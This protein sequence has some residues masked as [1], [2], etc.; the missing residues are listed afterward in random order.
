MTLDAMHMS[1]LGNDYLYF[2][3]LSEEIGLD[4][5]RPHVVK[6]SAQA[7]TDGVIV[8]LAHEQAHVQMVIFNRDGSRA[9]MCGNGLR[10]VVRYVLDYL[11]D[12]QEIL[13]ETDAGPMLGI[14]T[15]DGEICVRLDPPPRIVWPT[16]TLH[17]DQ[18]A[19]V[20][21]RV[22]VGNPHVVI[23]APLPLK[24]LPLQQWGPAIEQNQSLFPE[25]TNVEF[26]TIDKPGHLTMR[27]W[28]RGSGETKACG[29]GAAAVA[30]TYRQQHPQL[31]C[32]MVAMPGGILCFDWNQGQFFMTGPATYVRTVQINPTTFELMSEVSA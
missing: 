23:E 13:V 15:G 22:S 25:K 6:L 30:W 11:T 8:M 19:L 14:E 3:G 7:Q 17:L 21:H 32:V 24:D 10:C 9:Q 26:Y 2:D 27:V 31:D 4:Q 20:Y 28:E 29:T 5:L 18:H 1:A 12:D 16:Q